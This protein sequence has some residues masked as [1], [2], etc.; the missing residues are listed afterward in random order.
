M[1][2]GNASIW[3]K[4]KPGLTM[5]AHLKKGFRQPSYLFLPPLA[6]TETPGFASL[7]HS[8]FAFIETLWPSSAS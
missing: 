1:T 5:L 4:K 8:K 7:L 2:A 6:Q 3:K